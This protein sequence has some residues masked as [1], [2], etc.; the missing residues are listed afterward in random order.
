MVK[1][2]EDVAFREDAAFRARLRDHAEDGVVQN[3]DGVVQD[4]EDW[5]LE[6]CL[7]GSPAQLM[8]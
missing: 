6:F 1:P 2:A 5:G 7:M 3:H 8:I 4:M